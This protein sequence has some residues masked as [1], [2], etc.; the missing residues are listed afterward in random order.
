M[1]S[2]F[3]S[4][5]S[6]DHSSSLNLGNEVVP[7]GLD[8]KALQTSRSKDTADNFHIKSKSVRNNLG[9]MRTNPGTDSAFFTRQ[10][11]YGI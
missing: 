4:R 8:D 2:L 10:M 7:R 1:Q 3:E 6:A 9:G 11:R 5:F